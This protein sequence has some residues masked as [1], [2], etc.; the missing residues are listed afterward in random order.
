MPACML[1]QIMT[2]AMHQVAMKQ[3]CSSVLRTTTSAALISAG[4]NKNPYCSNCSSCS[5]FSAITRLR[6]QVRLPSA[7]YQMQWPNAMAKCNGN[8]L[9][10]P[11][12]RLYVAW[13]HRQGTARLTAH[14]YLLLS[15]MRNTAPIHARSGKAFDERKR[16]TLPAP[17]PRSQ[18][19]L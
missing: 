19:P 17:A 6:R 15:R 9:H 11:K 5:V 4:N 7:R 3:R 10:L 1:R 18:L 14:Q 13:Q 16:R 2:G 12:L 8:T